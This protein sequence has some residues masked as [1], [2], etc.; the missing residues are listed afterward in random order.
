M[1]KYIDAEALIARIHGHKENVKCDNEYTNKVY[2]LA[3]E[4]IIEIIEDELPTGD[5]EE[6]RHATWECTDES[7]NVWECSGKDGCGEQYTFIEGTPEGNR[8]MRCPNCGARM[9]GKG[10]TD[11]ES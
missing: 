1:S 5:V 8:Y 11:D 7:D 2:R 10:K 9:D 4:H 3:H 6:V